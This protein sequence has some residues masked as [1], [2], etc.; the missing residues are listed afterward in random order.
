[1]GRGG[2]AR[3]NWKSRRTAWSHL[4]TCVPAAGLKPQHEQMAQFKEKAFLQFSRKE[5][6]T[7]NSTQKLT[8]CQ[9]C[10]LPLGHLSHRISGPVRAKSLLSPL[11]RLFLR[12]AQSRR[13]ILKPFESHGQTMRLCPSCL[14]RA[15]AV[16]TAALTGHSYQ[17]IWASLVSAT[18]RRVNYKLRFNE[19]LMA[20][21]LLTWD[22]AFKIDPWLRLSSRE[23]PAWFVLA[24]A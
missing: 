12:R 11:A 4:P 19:C 8:D 22:L 20:S 9:I 21:V 2:Y 1:M 16:S 13:N 6:L 24:R 7:S 23:T 5:W 14:D 15:P 17:L 3:P 18:L 10:L